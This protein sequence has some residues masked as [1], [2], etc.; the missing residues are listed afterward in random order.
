MNSSRNQDLEQ[1]VDTV[2]AS[3]KYRNVCRDVITNIGLRELTKERRLKEAIKA[4]KN[5][6]HQIGGAY[7]ETKINYSKALEEL[8][9]SLESGNRNA[10]LETCKKLMQVHSSTRERLKIIEEFYSTIL[11]DIQ[12]IHVILDIACGFNPLSIPWMPLDDSLEYYAY[13]I[14]GDLIQFI[15]K[16]ISIINIDGDA[17]VCDITQFPPNRNADLALIL[18]TIP[19][20]EQ[21]DKSVSL[22]LLNS[23]KAHHLLVSFPI[24]SLGGRDKGM[25]VNYETRFSELI[26]DKMTWSVKRFEFSNEIAFLISK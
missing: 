17:E 23:I 15:K 7:F 14:Y 19:C 24:Q 10:F 4:T 20:I 13:D 5:K 22:R 1:L 25:A 2:L 8:K 11:D 16:F 9:L 26:S 18:K 3:S 21:I 6:L 12:P